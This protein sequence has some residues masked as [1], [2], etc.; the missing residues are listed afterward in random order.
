MLRHLI[1]I[2]AIVFLGGA[3]VA[4]AEGDESPSRY[5][6]KVL[7]L[8]TPEQL[9]SRPTPLFELWQDYVNQ[10]PY[11]YEFE[12]P[13][14]MVVSPG[15][16]LYG[17]LSTGLQIT[18]NGVDQTKSEWVSTLDMFVNVTFSGT[19]RFLI[20]MSPLKRQNGKKT[21]FELSPDYSFKNENNARISVAFF[22]GEISEMF[23]KIDMEGRLPLDYEIAIGRQ[24]VLSQGGVLINDT[25]DSIAI[26]RSTVPIKG[27]NFAR[28][29]GLFAWNNVNRSN[30]IDD[31]DGLLYALFSSVEVAHSN[32][33]IDLAYVDS[34]DAIG[35]QFNV[36]ATFIKPIIMFEHDVDTTIRIASS[37]TPDGETAQA[38]DGTMLYTS[39]SWAPKKTV[40]LIYLNAFAANNDYAPAA[41]AAGGPLGIT[42]LLFAPNGLGGAAIGNAAKHTYG[43]ALGYQ[44]F[45][46]PKLRRNLI[47]EIGGK[48]D[49]T[50]GGIDR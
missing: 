20:G 44:M 13:T 15:L 30:N 16:L 24:P 29:G 39:F 43:G 7:G 14:G 41:R 22:E 50:T 5:S 33:D 38:T 35:D 21:R 1:I 8:K 49:N 34:S 17:N 2:G 46:S 18:D 48:V 42:G 9:P 11:E 25:M 36:A 47:F 4:A 19:E 45:F 27:T 40:D 32:I 10:G 31:D 28:I 26:T 37:F 23:P 3:T 6:D 12:F